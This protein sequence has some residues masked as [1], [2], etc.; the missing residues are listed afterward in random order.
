MNS[1][2]RRFVA[3]GFAGMF[4]ASMFSSCAV[5]AMEQQ[6]GFNNSLKM[7][8]DNP[9]TGEEKEEKESI[10]S[11]RI[12]RYAIYVFV[13]ACCVIKFVILPK[14]QADGTQTEG[15]EN[16][17]PD[18]GDIPDKGE[19]TQTKE[20]NQ[21][22]FSVKK[23]GMSGRTKALIGGGVTTSLAAVGTGV[24]VAIKSKKSEASTDG[25]ENSGSYMFIGKSD[26]TSM[27]SNGLAEEKNKIL[28]DTESKLE[29]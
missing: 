13:F 2:S 27:A 3:A 11:R 20:E 29:P 25:T 22:Q 21:K 6:M 12:I 10:V 8:T 28:T 1:L 4:G 7:K 23:G 5:E 18:E 9:P 24:A 16:N 14:L 15:Q 26:A 19:S 17:G